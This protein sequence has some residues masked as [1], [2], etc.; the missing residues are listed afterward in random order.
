MQKS[1]SMMILNSIFL[2]IKKEHFNLTFSI[3]I[4]LTFQTLK[5]HTFRRKLHTN[6]KYVYGNCKI[7]KEAKK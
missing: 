5:H 2:N 4:S 1:I 3:T 6:S 7:E